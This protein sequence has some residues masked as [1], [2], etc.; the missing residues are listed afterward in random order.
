[1]ASICKRTWTTPTGTVQTGWQVSYSD[2]AGKRRRRQ[3]RRRKDADAF[4]V[5][6]RSEVRDGT[7]TPESE[8]ITVAAAAEVWYE[9][10]QLGRNGRSGAEASTLRQYRN[11]IDLHIVPTIGGTRLANLTSPRV[12][13]FRDE[14]LKTKSR[15]MAGKILTSFKSILSECQARGLVAQNVAMPVRI[16]GSAR[17][18]EPVSIP[19]RPIVQT[20][21]KEADKQAASRNRQ[22]A[23][24][25]RRYRALVMTAALTGMRV[26]ELRGLAWVNVDF[27]GGAIEVR[28][29]ADEFGVIGSVK[30]KSARR[31]IDISNNLVAV[32][33]EWKLECPPGDEGLVFPN[34]QGHV[35]A[36]SN[37]HNRCWVPLLKKC[38]LLG[39]GG[40]PLHK[41]H[42]LRHFH[43]SSLIAAGATP[44]EVM[45][46]I[47]HSSIQ[48]TFDTYGHLFPEDSPAR[49]QRAA[50][51]EAEILS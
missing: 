44:K 49:K 12:V 28:Q 13:E 27:D 17:H 5:Q 8:S 19:S 15:T 39:E 35:E 4:L 20:V 25:W 36:L 30:S 41:F 18:K 43:A 2:Q 6:A 48:V 26:S 42:S 34:W 1:M 3:F 38:K 32:L 31:E 22:H 10:C 51:L 46:E 37:I 14:L 16:S 23:K 29:R 50:D 40:R 9:A 33:R 47:G 24:R 21:L 7:H 11:H 45:T